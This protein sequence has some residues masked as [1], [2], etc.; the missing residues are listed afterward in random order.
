MVPFESLGTASYS[1]SIVTMAVSSASSEIF[2]VKDWP[3]LEIWD[4]FVRLTI[5]ELLLVYHY[6]YSSVFTIF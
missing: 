5:F 6:N 2:G 4:G 1:Q 3:D